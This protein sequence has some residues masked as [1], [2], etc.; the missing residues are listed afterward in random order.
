MA[1]EV[2]QLDEI[3]LSQAN[4]EISHNTALRQIE[5]RTIG[6]L[7]RTTTTPPV[8]PTA[9]NCYIIPSGATGEWS[10]KTNQMAHFFGGVWNYWVPVSPVR[11]WVADA[12]MLVVWDGAAWTDLVGPSLT[13]PFV[14]TSA[15]V[16][17]SADATKKARL[18]VDGLTT[19]T[20]R[21]LTV[22][23]KDYTLEETGHASKHVSGGSDSIKLDDLAAPDDNTDLNASSSAHG[24]L[25][26]LSA[27][28]TE[29]LDGSG[30]WSTPAGTGST[31]PVT[32]TTEVVKGS[33]D[34]TKKLRF[35]VDGFTTSTTRVLTP[36][37]KDY[38]I[39]DKAD[40][41]SHT[42]SVAAHHALVIQQMVFAPTTDVTTGDGAG[43]CVVPA[44]LNGLNLTRVH[45]RVI[46]AGTTGTTDI[47]I[48]NV[49][50]AADMLSTKITIDSGETGSDT[51]ATAP[52]I[53]TGNDDV[54]TN[55]LLRIDCD[56]VS[57]TKPKG[58]IITLE[59][60]L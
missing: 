59:F 33:A 52:V 46:T 53:D 2:L 27:T 4:K 31:L 56:A 47:Q 60:S 41:D 9:G 3:N 23:N 39:A 10:G 1:T 22:Q 28:A 43:Y 45:A 40:L 5:G 26:K 42:A 32:D 14:D 7:S 54:A 17:G 18:E 37:N 34:A 25:R 35:E 51:A 12:L 44:A 36:Q 58:L 20:T 30:A 48:A 38:T 19:A 6:V 50:Q 29:Y 13:P 57:T 55:D 8:T 49:T 24:L 16:K 21:V 11:L 15:L